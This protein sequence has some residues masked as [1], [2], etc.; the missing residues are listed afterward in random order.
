MIVGSGQRDDTA[1]LGIVSQTTPALS[2][3]SSRTGYMEVMTPLSNLHGKTS[4][5]VPKPS[6]KTCSVFTLD[7]SM[8]V[9]LSV[10]PLTRAGHVRLL[11]DT[12]P[13]RVNTIFCFCRT[14]A[15]D[16]FCSFPSTCAVKRS[17]MDVQEFP[18]VTVIAFSTI[19]IFFAFY[20]FTNV[21]G[22]W[23]Y[24]MGQCVKVL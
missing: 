21:H 10:F 19:S 2:N 11:Q 24:S 20:E 23:T 7:L 13:D 3:N 22:R 4:T 9:H 16:C 1:L 17:S 15:F 18:M 8:S 5:I 14:H 12:V 6:F